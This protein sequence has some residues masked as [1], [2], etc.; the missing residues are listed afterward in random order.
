M[1][2]RRFEQKLYL[3]CERAG[4]NQSDL[5]R[6]LGGVSKSTIGG[7]FA[8]ESRPSLDH[9]LKL[10]RALGVSLDYLADDTIESPP[11]S[12]FTASERLLVDVSREIGIQGIVFPDS[13]SELA[14][15]FIKKLAELADA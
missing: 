1:G 8:G 4:W 14:S 7:W 11:R 3:L 2:V 12:E 9:C 15:L 10:A 13:P 6:E 5:S